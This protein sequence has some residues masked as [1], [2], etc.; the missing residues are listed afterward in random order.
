M[1]AEQL[2]WQ[3]GDLSEQNT[4]VKLQ[5]AA[6]VGPANFAQSAKLQRKALAYERAA[7]KLIA[8]QVQIH[9]SEAFQEL[10]ESVGCNS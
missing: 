3:A 6:L 2:A 4:F 7:E 5:A 8:E 1:Q 10:L 9:W